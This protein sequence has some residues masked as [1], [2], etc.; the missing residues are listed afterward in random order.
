MKRLI[1]KFGIDVLS[2]IGALLVMNLW[3]MSVHHIDAQA[4]PYD[5]IGEFTRVIYAACSF[6]IF[7]SVV[8]IYMG[9]K[10]PNQDSYMANGQFNID[11]KKLTPWQ[12]VILSTFQWLAFFF[13][14][15]ILSAV[16]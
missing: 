13:A 8:K 7:D 4:A 10:W 6:I 12:K 14:L 1:D 11:F 5:I 3:M 15:I 2:A 16:I 9:L